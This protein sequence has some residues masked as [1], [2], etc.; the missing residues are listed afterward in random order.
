MFELLQQRLLLFSRI[1][2]PGPHCVV[3]TNVLRTPNPPRIPQGYP[4]PMKYQV[5][6]DLPDFILLSPQSSVFGLL[7]WGCG[8]N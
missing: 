5:D 7:R 1:A 2:T 8:H 3:C 4:T 6:I